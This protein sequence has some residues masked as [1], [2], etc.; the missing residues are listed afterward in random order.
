MNTILKV[1]FIAA[2]LS[3]GALSGIVVSRMDKPETDSSR[4]MA[5]H[6]P[7][8]VA[9]GSAHSSPVDQ[10]IF[11]NLAK[12]VVPS[13]VNIQTTS[14]MKGQPQGPYGDEFFR[15]F[16]EDFFRRHGGPRGGGEPDDE[17]D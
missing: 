4:G 2:L 12:K 10:N 1:S 11:V 9:F 5:V 17:D 8:G 13:V 3:V 6:V 15:R 14:T 7:S 16:F